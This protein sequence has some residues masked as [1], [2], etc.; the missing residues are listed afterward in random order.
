LEDENAQ[1]KEALRRNDISL[2]PLRAKTEALRI[3]TIER[4][5][6]EERAGLQRET[7]NLKDRLKMA[8]DQLKR[9]QDTISS[10]EEKAANA[11]TPGSEELEGEGLNDEINTSRKDM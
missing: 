6:L 9:N 1:L 2:S 8:N 5:W 4:A 11:R 3:E 10:L 7:E